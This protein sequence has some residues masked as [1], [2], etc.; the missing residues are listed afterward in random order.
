MKQFIN[1]YINIISNNENNFELNNIIQEEI[2]KGYTVRKFYDNLIFEQQNGNGY[3]SYEGNSGVKIQFKPDGTVNVTGGQEVDVTNG[4]RLT[5]GQLIKMNDQLRAELQQYKEKKKVADSRT[6]ENARKGF[7]ETVWESL[8]EGAA[9]VCDAAIWVL[10]TPTKLVSWPLKELSEALKPD[11]TKYTPAND[12]VAK[13]KKALASNARTP[14]DKEIAEVKK[15]ADFYKTLMD[16]APGTVMYENNTKKVWAKNNKGAIVIIDYQIQGWT[17]A[18][19]EQQ[20]Q[21]INQ[22]L[23]DATKNGIK[24][25]GSGLTPQQKVMLQNNPQVQGA[26]KK[27]KLRDEKAKGGFFEMIIRWFSKL[28]GGGGKDDNYEE[29]TLNQ[30]MDFTPYIKALVKKGTLP[31]GKYQFEYKG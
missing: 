22:A 19:A 25:D 29:Y 4:S 9:I 1:E 6:M 26:V 11:I 5:K 28:F 15:F 30:L 7:G 13:I 17:G 14:N 23:D 18:S 31:P 3:W 10:E 20:G 12:E 27:L 8:K 24:G 21:A 2:K 16:A